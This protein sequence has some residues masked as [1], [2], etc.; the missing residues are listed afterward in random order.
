VTDSDVVRP[1][2]LPRR[3]RYLIGGALFAASWVTLYLADGGLWA[4][5]VTVLALLGLFVLLN[6]GF[7]PRVRGQYLIVST[8][9]GR[10]YVELP[11]ITRIVFIPSLDRR[12]GNLRLA[13]P[14]NTLTAALQNLESFHDALGPAFVDAD[15]RG[16]AVPRSAR[17]V[18]GLEPRDDAPRWGYRT[19]LVEAL[20]LAGVWSAGVIAVVIAWN[21]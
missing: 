7:R 11:A 19:M 13:D 1:R 8:L 17:A 18:F 15:R 21:V 16:V 6:S 5:A 4:F 10:Q 9:C 12:R 2:T 20:V 14:H 3:F